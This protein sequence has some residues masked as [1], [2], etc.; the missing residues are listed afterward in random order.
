MFGGSKTNLVH[1]FG[2]AIEVV[3]G[4]VGGVDNINGGNSGVPMARDDENGSGSV[5]EHFLLPRL[6][7]LPRLYR[8]VYRQRW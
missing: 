5:W 2:E 6:Q 7:K 8:L 1:G 4:V 3:D